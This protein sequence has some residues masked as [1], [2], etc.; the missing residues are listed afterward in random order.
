MSAMKASPLTYLENFGENPQLD[1]MEATISKAEEYLVHVIKDTQCKTM[2]GL[3]AH[4]YFHSKSSQVQLPPTSYST[5]SHILR[6]PYAT[7]RMVSILTPQIPNLDPTSFG[8][9]IDDG[10][11]LADQAKRPIPEEYTIRCNCA[12]CAT[13]K[14]LCKKTGVMCC[15]FCSC[16]GTSGICKND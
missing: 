9:I 10:L 8:F 6:A 14:C 15:K 1:D 12:K 16:S 13:F 2:D 5:R 3:K 7:H 11:L 4:M